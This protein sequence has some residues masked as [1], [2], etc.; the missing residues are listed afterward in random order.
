MSLSTAFLSQ[1]G[2]DNF[3]PPGASVP[4]LSLLVIAMPLMLSKVVQLADAFEGIAITAYND[5]PSQG[6]LAI[7]D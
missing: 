3:N 5:D 2:E 7:L 6:N 1:V 4:A